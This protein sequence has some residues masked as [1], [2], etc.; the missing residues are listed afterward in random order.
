MILLVSLLYEVVLS[1]VSSCE[2]ISWM[3]GVINLIEAAES[4][5]LF[6]YNTSIQWEKHCI[7]TPATDVSL[8]F[9]LML[10]ISTRF[11]NPIITIH[12]KDEVEEEDAEEAEAVAVDAVTFVGTTVLT[13]VPFSN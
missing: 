7:S 6:A 5:R 4:D 3:S 1:I 8:S 11:L 2:E 12:Q 9:S 13:M 10:T